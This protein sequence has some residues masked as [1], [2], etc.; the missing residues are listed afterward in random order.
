[1]HRYLMEAKVVDGSVAALAGACQYVRLV[2]CTVL[3]AARSKLV[4]SL[5]LDCC[6]M[7]EAGQIAQPAALGAVLCARTAVLVGDDYQLPPLVVSIEAQ[8]KG[9]NISLFKRFME[10]H[11]AA[12]CSLTI[13]YRMNAEIMSVCNELIYEHRMS[14]AVPSIALAALHLPHPH[15]IS[16]PRQAHV[17]GTAV[18][19]A[20]RSDWLHAAL[21]PKPAVVFLDTDN[22]ACH[23]TALLLRAE[24]GTGEATSSQSSGNSISS[25]SEAAIVKHLVLALK[26]GGCDLREV[27]I[28]CPF[29][30]QVT[31]ISDLLAAALT[32]E[33]LQHC[34]VSTVDKYQGRDKGVVILSTVKCCLDGKESVGNLLRDWRRINVAIT[35]C[36]L[37]EYRYACAIS[38]TSKCSLFFCDM[39]TSICVICRAKRKLVVIGSGTIMQQVP[40]L[41]KFALM[42]ARRYSPQP[43]QRAV[44]LTIT[45][46]PFTSTLQGLDDQLA[47]G[48]SGVVLIVGFE[49]SS[50]LHLVGCDNKNPR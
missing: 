50:S 46:Y 4:R 15:L 44:S 47:C 33:D 12:V 20:L 14:C 35:R 9:M 39:L 28:I 30:A 24:S 38:L 10:A 16:P 34:E 11:P 2:A 48:R 29:R 19:I 26:A 36:V 41:Q 49:R 37:T 42:S 13:Q 32:A 5:C 40:V 31:L 43:R 18:S 21:Q 23:L 1:M 25:D 6:L 45:H 22:L 27:G 8:T 17:R 3:A 7:D